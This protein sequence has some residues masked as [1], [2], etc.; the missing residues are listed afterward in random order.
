[1]GLNISWY[2]VPLCHH[3][4]TNEPTSLIRV[5]RVPEKTLYVSKSKS[6]SFIKEKIFGVFNI[7]FGV[8]M[9]D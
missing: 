1:M 9:L 3:V 7:T 4:I 2:I 6:R 8:S 5:L